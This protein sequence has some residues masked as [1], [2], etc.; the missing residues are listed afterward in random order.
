MFKS[1]FSSSSM[2]PS[3]KKPFLFKETAEDTPTSTPVPKNPSIDSANS[4]M[5]G[6]PNVGTITDL[7]RIIGTIPRSADES[8]SNGIS[9]T[10][11]TREIRQHETIILF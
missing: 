9:K 2:L 6:S 4:N 1:N 11:K 3:K 8:A 5:R 10:T 7:E